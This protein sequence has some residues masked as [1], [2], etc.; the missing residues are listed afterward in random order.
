M[1]ESKENSSNHE[2]KN[3]AKNTSKNHKNK[4]Y[5]STR[6]E[7][8]QSKN[9]T[10]FMQIKSLPSV[11]ITQISSHSLEDLGDLS[12]LSSLL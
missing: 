3:Q 9:I 6:K 11:E 7:M 1:K 8:I 2:I 12:L 4:K 10:I 5:R